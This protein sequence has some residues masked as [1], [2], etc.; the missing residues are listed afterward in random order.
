VLGRLGRLEGMIEAATERFEQ[1]QSENEDLRLRCR[2]LKARR[3]TKGAA[4][5]PVP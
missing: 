2:R 3:R 1:L 5:E 4:G